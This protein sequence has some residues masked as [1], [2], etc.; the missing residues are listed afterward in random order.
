MVYHICTYKIHGDINKSVKDS[1]LLNNNEIFLM[2]N[3]E[4]KQRQTTF[5]KAQKTFSLYIDTFFVINQPS[6]IEDDFKVV[7]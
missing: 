2:F 4:G 6:E 3:S 7:S 1:N 5:S